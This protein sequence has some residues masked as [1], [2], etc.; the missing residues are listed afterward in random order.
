MGEKNI[1][2]QYTIVSEYNPS[3]KD[4]Q[5]LA[6]ESF[7]YYLEVNIKNKSCYLPKI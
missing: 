4:F 2:A 6:N 1:P 7:K 3:G 5:Q